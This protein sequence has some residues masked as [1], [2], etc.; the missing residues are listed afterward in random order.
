MWNIVRV[1]LI[2]NVWYRF[3]LMTFFFFYFHDYYNFT[4]SETRD[5][6]HR[7]QNTESSNQ[8]ICITDFFS[9]TGQWNAILYHG[10]LVFGVIW[11]NGRPSTVFDRLKSYGACVPHFINC[12]F[13]PSLVVWLCHHLLVFRC[14]PFSPFSRFAHISFLSPHLFLFCFCLNLHR[15]SWEWRGRIYMSDI[16]I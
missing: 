15:A 1:D 3:L 9:K 10:C 12:C 13:F 16:A 7:W 8:C 11:A 6:M 4:W 14:P 5:A 2:L